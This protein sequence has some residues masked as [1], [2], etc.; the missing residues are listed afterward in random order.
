MG[1]VSA[2]RVDKSSVVK[3]LT[4]DIRFAGRCEDL[5]SPN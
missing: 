5:S 1:G 4:I 2:V 3:T